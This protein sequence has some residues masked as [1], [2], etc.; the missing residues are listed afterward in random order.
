MKY[1]LAAAILAVFTVTL[2]AA[3]AEITSQVFRRSAWPVTAAASGELRPIVTGSTRDL[4]NLEAFALTLQ[5]GKAPAVVQ[6]EAAEELIVVTS[7]TARLTVGGADKVLSRGGTAV[8][9]AGEVHSIRAEGDAPADAYV[10]RFHARAPIDAA[11]GNAA[12]GSFA[13]DRS[14][15]A[16]NPSEIGGQWRYFDR[17]TPMLVRFELHVSTLNA[18][19]ASHPPHTHRAAE[20]ILVMQGDVEMSIDGANHPA[21]AGDLVFLASEIP[22]GLH[23]AG[24]GPTEYFAFQFE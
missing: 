11:R 9:L 24:T 17:A 6:S 22:H 14:E 13:L 23:N 21:T 10:F 1:P 2:T 4:D 12:G 5:P 15:V 16:F 8:F 19:V 20:F 18:G 3:R 7:G